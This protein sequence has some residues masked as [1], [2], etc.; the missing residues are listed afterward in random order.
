MKMSVIMGGVQMM[1][2]LLLRVANAAHDRN[3]LDFLCE[4][5]PMIV[6]ML[7]FFGF[8]D[9]Q[10]LYKWVTFDYGDHEAPSIINSMIAM[11]MHQE[12]KNAMFGSAVPSMLMLITVL[13][14]PVMLIPKP[15]AIILKQRRAQRGHGAGVAAGGTGTGHFPLTDDEE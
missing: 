10:I 13:T 9:F 8:M 4:C 7:A 12:D 1:V 14:I 6:F 15:L 3:C 2:G 5:V 11:G